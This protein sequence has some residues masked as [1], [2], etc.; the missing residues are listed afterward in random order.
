MNLLKWWMRIVGALYLLEGGG[1]SLMALFVPGEFAAMWASVPA[2]SL[3]EFAVRGTLIAGLPGV[4]TW[5][6]LGGLLWF[7]SR[8]PAQARVLVITVVAWELCVWLPLDLIGLFNGF[9][10]A[11]V[12]SLVTIH[13]VIGASGMLALRLQPP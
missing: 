2:G 6:L 9:E 7:Y 12:A 13:A 10:L 5:V 8:V 3:S 11:R 1:L 4:L